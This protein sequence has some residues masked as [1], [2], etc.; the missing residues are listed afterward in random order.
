MCWGKIPY[1]TS[2]FALKHTFEYMGALHKPSMLYFA[3]IVMKKYL[4]Y[5]TEKYQNPYSYIGYLVWA[6]NNILSQSIESLP[7]NKHRLSYNHFMLLTSL[8]WLTETRKTV[9][10]RDLAVF[11]H[12]P[13]ITVSTTVKKLAEKGYLTVRTSPLD[14][15][16]RLLTLTSSGLALLKG[17]LNESIKKETQLKASKKGDLHDMLGVLLQSLRPTK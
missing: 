17:M 8:Y 15:R 14:K 12:M 16:S 4:D 2:V 10:Q 11:S 9:N 3:R 13:Q 1:F 6:V 5:H 7:E